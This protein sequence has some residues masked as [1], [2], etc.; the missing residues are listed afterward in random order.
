MASAPFVACLL[1]RLGIVGGATQNCAFCDAPLD[2]EGVHHTTCKHNGLAKVR[3]DGITQA[4]AVLARSA[5][6]TVAV[7]PTN[8]V[9]G[10]RLK[11]ADVGIHG[12]TNGPLISCVDVTVRS[13]TCP[14]YLVM[15]QE[16]GAVARQADADKRRKYGQQVV[17]PFAMETYGTLSPSARFVLKKLVT[18]MIAVSPDLDQESV[19]MQ[20]MY[21]LQRISIALQKGNAQMILLCGDSMSAWRRTFDVHAPVVDIR[22]AEAD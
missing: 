21:C 8:L 11:P 13:P 16:P 19:K 18:N 2:M 7:E 12:F 15:G 20:R 9:A 3:H 6:Y 10:T 14:T 22:A 17:I 5:G 4:V 1:L